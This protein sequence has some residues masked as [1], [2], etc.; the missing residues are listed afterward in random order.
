M[1]MEMQLAQW[2]LEFFLIRKMLEEHILGKED[3]FIAN[4]LNTVT[5]EDGRRICHNFMY[6]SNDNL[7]KSNTVIIS[8]ICVGNV[9]NEST[10]SIP[11]ET[12]T[13]YIWKL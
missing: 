11:Q 9:Y 8:E 10:K 5:E 1:W 4:F 7:S 2:V 6:F 3:Q 13:K 12:F